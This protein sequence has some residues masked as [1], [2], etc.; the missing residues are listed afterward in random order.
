[1]EST[2]VEK[3]IEV[4]RSQYKK[5]TKRKDTEEENTLTDQR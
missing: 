4:Y 1:M 2:S 5:M 3:N